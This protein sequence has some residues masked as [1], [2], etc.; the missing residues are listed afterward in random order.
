M[1]AGTTRQWTGAAETAKLTY[2]CYPEMAIEVMEALVSE[3]KARWPIVR[4]G[5]FH[6]LGEVPVTETSVLIGVATPHRADA[7]EVAQFLID[8]L[9]EDVPIW[10]QETYA[11]GTTG[12]VGDPLSDVAPD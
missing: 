10:K 2:D 3:A 5:V 1:F 7:F 11:D 9:K 8:R 12:W 4:V 6:R